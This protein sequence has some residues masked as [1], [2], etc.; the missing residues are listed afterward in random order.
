MTTTTREAINDAPDVTLEPPRPLQR[1][2]APPEPFPVDA[3]G[4]LAPVAEAI[5]SRTQAPASI[6]AQAVLAAAAHAVQAH[7]SIRLPHGQERPVSLYL[8]TVADSG[9]R[10]TTAEG[11]AMRPQRAREAELRAL[12]GPAMM[13]FE[14]SRDVYDSERRRIL[15]D[16]KATLDSKK[17]DLANL[18]EAPLPPAP[19]LLEAPEPTIEGLLKL[20]EH[21]PS[22]LL[23]SSE[24]GQFLGGYGM[25]PDHKLKTV[26][27]L[28]QWWDGAALRRVRAGDGAV[29][30]AGRR[31]TMSLL[32]QPGVALGFIGDPMLADQGTHS[33]LLVSAPASTA[34]SRFSREPDGTCE[35]VIDDYEEKLLRILRRRPPQDDTGA[36]TPRALTFAPDAQRVWFAF[37]D[38]VER[39][40]CSTGALAPIGAFASKL[41]EHA[42]RL[43]AVLALVEDLETPEV[44]TA[45][46]DA[47]IT[48]AEF[49]A[50]EWERLHDSAATRPEIDRAAQLLRW[51][52]DGWARPVIGL[53]EIY[54]RGPYVIRDARTAR[55][56]VG[57]LEDHG[58]IVKLAA[59]AEIDGVRR[60]DAWQIVE[61]EA[62]P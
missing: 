31:L 1:Q 56:A 24:G 57:V 6:P 43:A 53:P 44:T 28:S 42:A 41:G 15:G 16:R 30:L 50:S 9:A 61:K 11:D 45:H 18:G 54:Q 27:W 33:R 8:V 46:L 48:L 12:Y 22:L 39:Q 34:G 60:R 2:L 55:E 51:L 23:N 20:A 19:P 4:E 58:H 52:H 35:G 21:Q 3:L 59:G 36:L 10:K 26:S 17:A 7:A 49:Y 32:M 62:R 14:N 47:G 25:S 5:R 29:S 13:R 38:N 40:L 37:S